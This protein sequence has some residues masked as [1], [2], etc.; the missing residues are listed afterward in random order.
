M[1]VTTGDVEQAVPT[2]SSIADW[3]DELLLAGS[4]PHQTA[5]ECLDRLMPAL[6]GLRLLD[7][8]CGQGILTRH[9]AAE[10]AEVTGTDFA[11][12]MIANAQNH[13]TPSGL[14]IDYEVEDAQTLASLESASFDGV[15]CQLGLMDLPDLDACLQSVGRVLKPGG[16][17]AF[18][19]G[20]PAFLVPGASQTMTDDGRP[21]TVI[22][23]YFEPRFW[24]STNPCGVRRAG[25]YHRPLSAYLNSLAGAGFAIERAEEPIAN[26]L[27]AQQQPL[28]SRVPIFFAALARLGE[29]G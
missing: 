4:G 28:Y 27:L 12:P 15:T 17:L 14:T 25:N 6:G 3:Y 22:T 16:W 8:C 18:V 29:G 20:H 9:L 7:I 5:V 24:R 11:E 21:A 10:G 1:A 13:G 19:I 26:Q 2:W 23:D